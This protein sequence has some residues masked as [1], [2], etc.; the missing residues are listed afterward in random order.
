MI[1]KEILDRFEDCESISFEGV[2]EL[3][4]TDTELIIARLGKRDRKLEKII[5]N[6]LETLSED[7]AAILFSC[8]QC[9]LAPCECRLVTDQYFNEIY[10]N[11]LKS[12]SLSTAK[13]ITAWDN[14]W[15]GSRISFSGLK[16]LPTEI[17]EILSN[18][19][20]HNF[21]FNGL[22]NIS[23]ES[24]S[25]LSLWK[26]GSFEFN[27]LT[28]LPKNVAS[29]ISKWKPENGYLFLNGLKEISSE[30]AKKLS[31][32]QGSN[33]KL[34]GIKS[35][36][37]QSAYSL[38]KWKGK[39]LDLRG[40]ELLSN[41]VAKELSIWTG[42]YLNLSG[43]S[44]LNK[45][46][47]FYLSQSKIFTLDLSGLE[48][49]SYDSAHELSKF[50][51]NYLLIESIKSMSDEAL[52]EFLKRNNAH[53]FFNQSK[54]CLYSG[55]PEYDKQV[56]LPYSFHG[57]SDEVENR[58]ID[59]FETLLS[60]KKLLLDEKNRPHSLN[61]PALIIGDLEIYAIHG[62][63]V[64]KHVVTT[65]NLITHEDIEKQENIL[66][67]CVILNLYGFERYVAEKPN[68]I[69]FIKYCND[70]ESKRLIQ[71][72]YTEPTLAFLEG[73]F[74]DTKEGKKLF[75]QVAKGLNVIIREDY[76]MLIKGDQ[77]FIGYQYP[78][79][80]KLFNLSVESPVT[81]FERLPDLMGLGVPWRLL[82]LTKEKP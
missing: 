43:V 50:Q 62:E 47:A 48:N 42:I 27:G 53:M 7:S 58:A 8:K 64:S 5:F 54:S 36:T 35:L 32:W 10:F 82:E 59:L 4:I 76:K 80:N 46:L 17:A 25:A 81:G 34:S 2:V 65:P 33:L 15:S 21:E 31:A 39:S 1:I 44:S 19:N 38:A 26:G 45:E 57:F 56:F 12:I 66:V 6:N 72:L 14:G 22:E 16:D 55:Q 60:D 51:G 30:S 29:S 13:I 79:S 52:Y 49:I 40:I 78:A 9:C 67:R 75:Q 63:R 28:T 20:G 73:K 3:S 77:G 70:Y 74:T 68:N 61:G 18:W 11:S 69:D 37:Q 71:L 41:E 24:M 23:P